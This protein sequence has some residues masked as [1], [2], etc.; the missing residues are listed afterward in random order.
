MIRIPKPIRA[1]R[2]YRGADF[3]IFL[4]GEVCPLNRFPPCQADFETSSTFNKFTNINIHDSDTA[5]FPIPNI[6]A[7]PDVH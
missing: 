6:R 7:C 4:I 2:Y 5:S 1:D 3:F